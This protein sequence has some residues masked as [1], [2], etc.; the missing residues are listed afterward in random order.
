MPRGK[1][2]QAVLSDLLDAWERLDSSGQAKFMAAALQAA[3]SKPSTKDEMLFWI[4]VL[5]EWERDMTAAV[6]ADLGSK[7]PDRG[8]QV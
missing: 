7:N 1:H 3:I 2:R 5:A 8:S 4:T 6:I